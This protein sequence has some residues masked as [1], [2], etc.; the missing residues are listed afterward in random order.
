MTAYG[1]AHLRKVAM[2]P[3]IVEYLRRIDETL[4]PFGGRFIVHGGRAEVLEGD[5]PG[6]LIVIEFPDRDHARAW[7]AS[8]AYQE[9]LRLR[10][11]NAEGD[12][13]LVDG[14]PASHRAT[15]VLAG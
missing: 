12:V 1:V 13:I 6:D 8:P 9:I 2:G 3:A 5:W 10:T 7:Y 4:Q 11:D 15:D 14:V